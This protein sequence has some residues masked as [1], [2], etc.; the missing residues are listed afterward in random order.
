MTMKNKL[1]ESLNFMASFESEPD[2][3]LREYW[4]KKEIKSHSLSLTPSEVTQISSTLTPEQKLS[5]NHLMENLDNKNHSFVEQCSNQIVVQDTRFKFK[6]I[7]NIGIYVPFKLPSTAYTFLSSA[8]AAGVNNITVYLAEDPETGKPCPLSVYV[9]QFYNANI[10]YG[11]ARFAFPT[12]TLGYKKDSIMPVS[13]VCGPCSDSLNLLKQSSSIYSKVAVDMWAGSSDLAIIIDETANL[14]QVCKDLKAQLEHG[15]KSSCHIVSECSNIIRQVKYLLSCEFN[16]L[17]IER[18]H[19]HIVENMTNCAEVINSLAPETTELWVKNAQK[20]EPLITST[21]V[22]YNRMSSSFGDYGV[23]GRGCA[24][25]TGGRAVS[26][27]G[28]SPYTFMRLQPFIESSDT[29]S[30]NSLSQ[31]AHV[32]AK[33]EGLNC[34][35]EAIS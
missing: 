18:I 20:I 25:P 32:V 33:Y 1:I 30:I 31:A 21:G 28:I 4:K 9:C 8:R 34:H 12:L 3:L 11:P 29:S 17:D 13:K 2:V 6:V 5:L 27:S 24:D 19:V 16:H 14:N 35:L 23:I 22:I 7:N 15:P 10:L 26:D